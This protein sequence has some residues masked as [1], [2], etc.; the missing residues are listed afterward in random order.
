MA[1]QS[2]IGRIN[3]ESML[4]IRVVDNSMEDNHDDLTRNTRNIAAIYMADPFPYTEAA[5]AGLPDGAYLYQNSGGISNMDG[6]YLIGRLPRYNNS[7]G[8]LVE[9]ITDDIHGVMG[10]IIDEEAL[11]NRQSRQLIIAKVGDTF[12]F[13]DGGV[14]YHL[15]VYERP[16]YDDTSSV[17]GLLA[18][19]PKRLQTISRQDLVRS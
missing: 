5:I 17:G 15:R 7:V 11:R 1:D 8:L 12:F 2:L 18:A 6:F 9:Q 16:M 19:L 4:D 13:G 14:D 3:R 10:C